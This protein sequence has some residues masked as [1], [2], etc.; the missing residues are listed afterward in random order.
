MAG[1]VVIDTEINVYDAKKEIKSLES[2]LKKLEAEKKKVDETF[3]QY[4]EMG[5]APH[6][7]E[8]KRYD[9]LISKIKETKNGITELN[10]E[11][12]SAKSKNT[13]SE[14]K[15]KEI[16][17]VKTA[18]DRA[19]KSIRKMGDSA[20]KSGSGFKIGLKSI[21]RYAFSIRSLFVLIN[22]LR[23]ALVEGFKNLAQFNNGVNPTNTALSNLKSSL[24]QLKNSFAVAFAPILTVIEP[25]ITRLINLLSRA[26]NAVGQFFAALT[27]ATSFTTA[28]AINE[29]YA[30]SLNNIANNAN[31]AKKQLFGI[32]DLNNR[33]TSDSGSSGSSTVNPNQM[34]ETV[35]IENSISALAD[36]IMS[37]LRPI[38][39]S[40]QSWFNNIDFQP[41]INSF[42]RLKESAQP[43]I[44]KLGQGVLWLLENV[45]EPLGSWIIEDAGPASVDFLSASLEALNTVIELLKPYGEWLWENFLKPIGKWAGEKI[46]ELLEKLTEKLTQFTQ[47]CKTD[48][49]YA[50]RMKTI[51]FSFL[52]GLFT[53]LAVK[54]IANLIGT[55]TTVFFKFIGVLGTGQAMI[56]L[57]AIAISVL[58]S[59]II[60]L[61]QNWD[62]LSPAERAITILGALAA[63]ATAAA[64]AIAIFHTAWSVGLAAAAIAGGLALLGLTFAFSNSG[65]AA[66][67]KKSATKF[68]NSYDFG[69]SPLPQLA[70]GT[71]VPRQ[72]KEF[73]AILGDNN[74]ETEV[75]SPLSTM[76]QAFKEALAEAGI[77]QGGSNVTVVLEG[78]AKGVFRL[79][80]TEEEKY[81][82]MTG[83]EVFVH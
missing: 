9:D 23:S 63:A 83:R 3:S 80:R 56:M 60:Y 39:E 37:I 12:N 42:V 44:D 13:G 33:T 17:K 46:I 48:K 72:S 2:D 14:D 18:S 27:G 26:M 7:K 40:L 30:A 10:A 54:K 76:K 57:A 78:D 70:T 31:K 52:G 16:E 69:A 15:A 28:V 1:K 74:R 32:Y 62:K 64:I 19:S 51:I 68:Y 66:S 81:Y 35:T 11:I 43:L 34:F 38:R 8:L 6:Q 77:G 29:N 79:V 82:N 55:L 24:T 5:I 4:K 50:E 67:S 71:V 45:L 20:K 47:R 25:I 58:A 73:A 41:L 22:K 21:L 61:Y 53:Y 65:D 59:G 36:R 75:V 49:E